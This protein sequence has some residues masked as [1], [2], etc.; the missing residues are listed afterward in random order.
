[1]PGPEN[2]CARLRHHSFHEDVQLPAADQAVIVCGVLA[3]VESQVLRAFRFDHLAR[4]I[5]DFGLH[6]S[7]ADSAG[8]GA[9]LA[10]QQFGAFVAGNRAAHLHNGRQ[11]AFLTQPAQAHEFLVEVHCW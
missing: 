11:G 8:H 10:Y 4:G 1:M 5:P 6:A 3:E 7:A 2:E 9:V